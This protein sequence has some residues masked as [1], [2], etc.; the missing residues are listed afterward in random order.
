M[1]KGS[2][3]GMCIGA[4]WPRDDSIPRAFHFCRP[5]G[6]PSLTMREKHTSGEY[7]RDRKL[8]VVSASVQPL[9]CQGQEDATQAS[10]SVE[11]TAAD[12]RIFGG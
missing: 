4:Y 12:R 7:E 2:R 6:T 11:C 1:V 9:V 3:K 5:K 8:N 10:Q